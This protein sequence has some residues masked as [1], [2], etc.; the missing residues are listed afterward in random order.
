MECDASFGSKCF[1]KNEFLLTQNGIR[2]KLSVF[3][4]NWKK[5]F[6]P[7]RSHTVNNNLHFPF[8]RHLLLY[9]AQT[10]VCVSIRF[11]VYV[12]VLLWLVCVFACRCVCV[13]MLAS[14]LCCCCVSACFC[15]CLCLCV[16]C[17]CVV[18]LC[19]HVCVCVYVSISASNDVYG[20]S[21]TAST[22]IFC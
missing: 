16:V 19:V 9:F 20:T 2:K 8:S 10:C 14:V 3:L 4:L 13:S 21:C 15:L 12:F 6:K 11:C 22:I 18:C 1:P 7:L 5:R 17:L